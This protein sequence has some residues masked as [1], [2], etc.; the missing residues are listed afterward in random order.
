[1][2]GVLLPTAQQ[3]I[4]SLEGD[5]GIGIGL[6][7]LDAPIA[8]LIEPDRPPGQRAADEL[9]WM[10]DLIIGIAVAQPCFAARRKGRAGLNE[11]LARELLELHTLGVDAD[12]TQEDVRGLALLLTGLTYRP[13]DGARFQPRRAEP[14]A[15]IVLGRRYGGRKARIEDIHAVLDDL[16]VHPATARHIAMKLAVH[17][18]SDEPDPAM[19]AALAEAWARRRL[20]VVARPAAALPIAARLLLEHLL[21]PAAG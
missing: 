3:R 5:R 21:Q 10:Q 6:L 19:V 17:F 14:G 12:Y 11:N 13:E 8:Q 2:S 20:L 16:A 4:V 7:A 9:A 18:S 15:D 1:M